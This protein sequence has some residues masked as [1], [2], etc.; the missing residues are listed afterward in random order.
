MKDQPLIFG[1]PEDT[2]HGSLTILA[3]MMIHFCLGIVAIWGNIVI[4]VASKLRETNEDLTIKFALFVFPMTLAMGSI[5]MQLANK[6][7]S[8]T[9][10]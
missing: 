6:L 5:G 3:G 1:V 8:L 4:Y 10:P 9:T 7:A 2:F